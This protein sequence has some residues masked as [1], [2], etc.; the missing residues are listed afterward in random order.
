MVLFWRLNGSD[1]GTVDLAQVT[2]ND[3]PN[4]FTL[5]SKRRPLQL[6]QLVPDL[7]T[8]C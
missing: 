3:M 5:P 8:Q 1:G 6:Q 2:T 4:L 7:S